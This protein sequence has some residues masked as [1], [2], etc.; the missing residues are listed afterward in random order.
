MLLNEISQLK[1]V[2]L[3]PFFYQ[4]FSLKFRRTG[5]D[6]QFH[7]QKEK[8]PCDITREAFLLCIKTGQSDYKNINPKEIITPE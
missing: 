7:P 5:T 1:L 3:A 4:T 6:C 8:R 2:H